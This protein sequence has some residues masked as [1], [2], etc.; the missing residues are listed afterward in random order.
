MPCMLG[1]FNMTAKTSLEDV[2][3]L[4][5]RAAGFD[6]GF[7]LNTSLQVV[8]DNGLSETI[9][10]T[11]NVWETA[12]MSGVF[13]EPQKSHLRDIHEEFLLEALSAHSWNL[14]PVYSSKHKLA[15]QVLPGQ[16]AEATWELNNPHG[17]QPLQF[18]LQ[19]SGDAPVSDVTIKSDNAGEILVPVTLQTGKIL[20]YYGGGRGIVYDRSWHELERVTLD[21][22]ELQIGPGR[23]QVHFRCRFHSADQP[24]VKLEFRTVGKAKTLTMRG[25]AR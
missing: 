12:R 23:H 5:A 10:Q 13:S 18:I 1:W 3:W 2:E 11:I 24:E 9:L 25:D 22:S 8:R 14:Y 21:A 4:L 15:P 7:A 6:A 17:A 20:K 16:L 19:V